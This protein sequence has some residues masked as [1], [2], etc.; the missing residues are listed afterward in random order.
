MELD[1]KIVNQIKAVC[2]DVTENVVKFANTDTPYAPNEELYLDWKKNGEY[3]GPRESVNLRLDWELSDAAASSDEVPRIMART[4]AQ[5][6]VD[7]LLNG[8]KQGQH[9]PLL[10]A[11]DGAKVRGK[12]PVDFQ[13]VS[14]M[15]YTEKRTRE[16]IKMTDYTLFFRPL[17]VWE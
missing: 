4:M 17:V 12:Q 1:E 5:D 10:N 7:L 14:A 16:K 11:M 3:T 6:F 13:C 15:L 2:A 9:D 8:D